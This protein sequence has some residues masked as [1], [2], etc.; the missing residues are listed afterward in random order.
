MGPNSI[1]TTRHNARSAN[2]PVVQWGVWCGFVVLLTDNPFT[3]EAVGNQTC[4]AC[5]VGSHAD[6]KLID[7]HTTWSKDKL[8]SWFLC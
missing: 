3:G 8:P 6:S 4:V 1:K 5:P 7:N 2:H